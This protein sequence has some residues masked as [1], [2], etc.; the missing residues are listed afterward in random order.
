MPFVNKLGGGSARR[1]G[2]TR[3]SVFYT[4]NTNTAIV[5]LS[6]TTCN[7]PANYSAT[8][9]TWQSGSYCP[10]GGANCS[11]TCIGAN[12]GC[13]CNCSNWCGPCDN[14]NLHRP[15]WSYGAYPTYTTTYSCPTNTSVVTLVSTSCNYPS[16][17]AA[18]ENG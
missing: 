12:Q 7:Y 8:A 3:R 1:F 11:G 18:T 4:C 9:W 16:A 15:E 10:F 2:F 14:A 6:G 17:Y 13:G 5:T